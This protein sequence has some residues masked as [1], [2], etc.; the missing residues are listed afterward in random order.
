MSN[1]NTKH[2]GY[3]VEYFYYQYNGGNADNGNFSA[4][5]HFS[6]CAQAMDMIEKI[7]QSI[8]DTQTDVEQKTTAILDYIPRGGF[9]TYDP[10]LYE[11][12]KTEL[13]Q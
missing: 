5:R 10:R 13:K 4:T 11:V 1:N 7:K 12:V 9:F 6:T 2:L 3:E 8:K